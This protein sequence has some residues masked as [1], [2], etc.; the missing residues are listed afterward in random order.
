MTDRIQSGR[1]GA[2]PSVHDALRAVMADVGAIAKRGQNRDQ[3]YRFRSIEQVVDTFYPLFLKHGIMMI[4]RVVE[5]EAYGKATGAGDKK[6][7]YTALTIEYDVYGPAHDRLEP[8]PRL[9]VHGADMGDKAPNKALSYGLKYMLAQMFMVPFIKQ[10]EGDE[11][12]PPKASDPAAEL[13]HARDELKRTVATYLRGSEM[14][15]GRWIVKVA[16]SIYGEPTKIE[17]TEQA[18]AVQA[19]IRDFTTDGDRIPDGVG[20]TR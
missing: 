15:P 8:C 9:T 17:T 1:P 6:Q 11:R 12:G 18:R 4:P 13:A 3:G 7:T 10:D 2:M 16:Q 20:E 5:H 19:A 14:A